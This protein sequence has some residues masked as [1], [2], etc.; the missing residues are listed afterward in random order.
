M[1]WGFGIGYAAALLGLVSERHAAD[2]SVVVDAETGFTFSQ[3]SAAY[4]LGADSILY[5]IAIP[6][7]ASDNY[8]AVLQVIAPTDV[9]WAGLAWGGQMI[10][11]PLTVGWA[12]GNT[13][14][15]SVFH[16]T[17]HI[18]PKPYTGATL[19]LLKTGT[20]VNATHWQYTAKCMGCT[21][22][23][24]SDNATKRLNPTGSNRLAFAESKLNSD[25]VG[26]LTVHDVYNYWDHD[27]AAA[28]NTEFESLVQK[29]M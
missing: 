29:N 14:V 8:D 22:F 3:Y 19:Q 25:S 6:S 12:S 9:G 7:P 16:S 15:V 1:R 23:I 24:G 21:S 10:N 5:R 13:P 28:G 27:F 20:K 4:K 2:T 11:C 17:S 26:G 18:E